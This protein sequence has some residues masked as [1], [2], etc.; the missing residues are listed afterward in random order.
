MIIGS[1]NTVGGVSNEQGNLV[2]GNGVS[3]I[4]LWSVFAT[5]NTLERNRVGTSVEGTNALGNGYYGIE[6][7]VGASHNLITHSQI[8]GTKMEACHRGDSSQHNRIIGNFIGLNVHASAALGN[9]TYGVSLLA[10]NNE[11]GFNFIGG[12]WHGIR[13]GMDAQG[14]YLHSN[15]IGLGWGDESVAIPNE[16]GIYFA[17]GAT[18]NTVIHN[19]IMHNRIGLQAAQQTT[20]NTLTL[21]QFAQNGDHGID[22][23]T[24]GIT[25]NDLG[26]MDEGANQLIN[27]PVLQSVQAHSTSVSITYTVDAGLRSASYPL[28]IEFFIDDGAGEGA[29]FLGVDTFT[30]DD[31][32]GGKSIEL[33]IDPSVT[34]G[35]F[36]VVATTTDQA[37]N[38]SEF[39]LRRVATRS[40]SVLT[41]VRSQ[42]ANDS[43]DINQDGQVTPLDALLVINELNHSPSQESPWSSNRERMDLNGDG[44]VTP[45]DALLVINFQ[46]QISMKE[47]EGE[48]EKGH[49]SFF[50]GGLRQ[51]DAST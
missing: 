22:L 3:G 13:L 33:P 47:K 5:N 34:G 9:R 17:N 14:N 38:T 36:A 2:S 18:N 35:A 16:F 50:S 25:E 19:S 1:G 30:I 21:N 6:L 8:A 32:V 10:P 27:T 24:E 7:Q 20:G 48:K 44:S 15:R 43:L 4:V 28:R 46:N 41:M 40:A 39:S 12:N 26:D 42:L 31:L 11:V 29:R 45:L 49:D 23:G 51:C 37:G